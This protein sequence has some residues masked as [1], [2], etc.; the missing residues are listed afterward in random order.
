MAAHGFFQE[1]MDY[2]ETTIGIKAD[3]LQNSIRETSMNAQLAFTLSQTKLEALFSE[4]Q[5]NAARVDSQVQ[6][7]NEIKQTIELKMVEH[8]QAVIASG[9]SADSAH[10]RL[11]SLLAE[12]QSFS[13]TTAAAIAEVK[14]SGKLTRKETM[15]EFAK[16][17]GNIE[18]WYAGIK[19]HLDKGGSSDGK[20][21][22][23]G[24]GKGNSRV[25]K[26]D[27]AVSKLPDDLDKSSFRHWVDAVDQQ[28]EAVHGFKH[29]SFVMNEIRRS[30][31]EITAATFTTCI[32]RANVKIGNSLEAM[33]I[34]GE[35]LNGVTDDTHGE[36]CDYKFLEMTTFL[37]SYLI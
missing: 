9:Q 31:A 8:Q 34:W 27:I 16:F 14:A 25:H 4:A 29:A 6:L 1:Q 12:L 30:D 11:T 13:D 24:D 5:A 28:L 7:V 26:K 18:L 35:E 32:E 22:G 2:I 3:E 17:R 37:N 20:G 23:G 33:G 36:F 19:S 15:D 10:A 21:K